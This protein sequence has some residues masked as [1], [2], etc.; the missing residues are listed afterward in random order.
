MITL[1]K[2]LESLK[3]TVEHI[4]NRL[5]KLECHV[6]MESKA[7]DITQ[8]STRRNEEAFKGLERRLFCVENK[9]EGCLEF[10]DQYSNDLVELRDKVDS[11]DPLPCPS[12]PSIENTLTQEPTHQ[13]EKEAKNRIT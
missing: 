12:V 8:S 9:V 13:L 11:R 2:A 10:L 5:S 4:A 6:Q 3:A 1:Q 7:V